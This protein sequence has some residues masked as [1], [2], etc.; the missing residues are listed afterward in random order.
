MSNK[1]ARARVIA[2]LHLSHAGVTRFL[3]ADGTKLRPWDTP[4]EMDAALIERWNSVVEE[5]D[6]VY[7][8][9]DVA[10]NKRALPLLDQLNG[11][12]VIVLG[13]H[14]IFGAKEYLKY[15]DDV[16]G[17]KVVDGPEGPRAILTHIPI[18]ERS[19]GRFVVNIHG[20]LHSN[21]VEREVWKGYWSDDTV[22]LTLVD[23]DRF[24]DEP[25]PRYVCVSAEH[26]DYTPVLLEEVI[27]EAHA[28]L[29][30]LD[31][32]RQPDAPGVG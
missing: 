2:D 21:V 26:I 8:L 25:D 27:A 13:N 6:R 7:I 4:E 14:D 22:P 29:A 31:M 20:H 3:R 5:F 1:R 30:S 32:L 16:R 12:K 17:S 23:G 18:H 15:V 10:I 11:K 19:I 28:K 9:G 24:E